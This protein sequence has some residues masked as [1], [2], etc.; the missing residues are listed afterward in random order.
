MTADLQKK[1]EVNPVPL[2]CP[3]CGHPVVR[4]SLKQ[5]VHL[6]ETYRDGELVDTDTTDYAEV[7]KGGNSWT[8]EACD[9]SWYWPPRRLTLRIEQDTDPMSPRE[10]DNL[11]IMVCFHGR[12]NLGDKTDLKSSMFNDWGELEA[13]L[14][15]N[16]DA[17][18]I[19]PLYLYDHSG[20]SMSTS[21]FHCGWD[22][23][24]V[25][26]I[27]TTAKRVA[28]MGVA[29]ENIE[30]QLEA[31]VKVYDQYLQG[32]VWGYIIEDEDGEQLDSCWGFYGRDDAE[33]EAHAAM[34]HV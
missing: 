21:G 2:K 24:R 10:H 16:E 6:V 5:A 4:R 12:Y 18:H 1:E 31:E 9:Q 11:G 30:Q 17:T 3:S 28:E 27:Y 23:G 19:L 34:E 7:L 33:A 32:D 29:E 13:H 25:G 20:L 15:E 8:C 26:F 22:S 14:K